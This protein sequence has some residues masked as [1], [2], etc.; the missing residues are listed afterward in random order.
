MITNR[1]DFKDRHWVD[2]M[3]GI[4]IAAHEG[5]LFGWLNQLLGLLTAVGLVLLTVSGVVLWWR[6]RDP[7]TLGAPK[8][9]L[10][11]R[12]STGLVIVIVLL[13]LYLPLFGL[14]LLIVLGLEWAVLCR[15]PS[16]RKWLGL[17]RPAVAVATT[18]DRS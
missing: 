6:R 11:P 3:V 1:E 13:G 7:G 2:R 18:G 5:Q 8:M 12:F 15:I 14:S 17:N 9:L 4:G 16:V 10:A